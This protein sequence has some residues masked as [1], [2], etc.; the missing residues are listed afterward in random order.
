M[1]TSIAFALF[2][3]ASLFQTGL[4]AQG[5]NTCAGAAANQ[6]SLPF[7]ANNQS[8]CGDLNDY[9][10]A[11]ACA[12]TSNG[13]YYGGQDWLYSFTPA[14]DG[15]VNINLT[16][17][18]SSGQAYPTVS[19]LSACPGT[20]GAC[21][22]FVQCSAWMG[23]GTIVENVQA[24]QTY[25]ILVDAYTWS[26]YFANCCQFDLSVSLTPVVVQPACSNINFNNGN[27]GSWYGTSGLSQMGTIGAITP[28]YSPDAYGLVNGRHTII[29]GGNDPCAGFPR[30]DP[31]GG[32]FS[33]RL[34]NNDVN[35]QAEQLMQTFMVSP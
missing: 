17:I 11:N 21:L 23:G 31:Q 24:G 14:Q 22:G 30:V 3:F 25:Y 35:S 20:A 5:S 6:I 34:G 10:G 29:T 7:F 15:F 1:K 27:L 2:I 26:T 9:S 33:V 4:R 19:L 28:N 32:P 16:D 18:V 13:N 12:V 8:L